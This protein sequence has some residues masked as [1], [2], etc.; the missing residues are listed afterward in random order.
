MTAVVAVLSSTF[1]GVAQAGPLHPERPAP[2]A[3]K[4]VR[5]ALSQR[6]TPYRWGGS[7][8]GRGFDCSGLVSWAYGRVGVRLPHSS[9][10][11][12]RLGRRVGWSAL[13][14]GDIVFFHRARHVGIYIGK[15]RFVHAPRRGDVVRVA[16]LG[17]WYGRAFGGARRV[18]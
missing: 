12:A 16:R 8:P 2:R 18:V 13:R 6:G 11:L 14:P 5:A 1:A 9:Y 10:A 7:A 3:A 4:A 17:G 15:G